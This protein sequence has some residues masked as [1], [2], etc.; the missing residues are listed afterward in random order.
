MGDEAVTKKRLVAAMCSLISILD[1]SGTEVNS[2]AIQ[3]SRKEG[4]IY[5]MR[6]Y[7]ARN[8]C[9]GSCDLTRSRT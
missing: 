7:T 2:K 5:L 8:K 4:L 1:D 9:G 6:M 3:K